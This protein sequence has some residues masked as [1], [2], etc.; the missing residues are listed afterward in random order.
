MTKIT[1][2]N[3]QICLLRKLVTYTKLANYDSIR[4]RLITIL[5]SVDKKRVFEATNG[6]DSVRDI[7]SDT[8]VNKATIS[9]WWNEW[10]KEGI[11]EECKEAKGR[12]SKLLS[13]SDFGIEVPAG[14]K[15]RTI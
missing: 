10:Q 6:R 13:L 7:Q 14:K 12:R 3:E 5:D 8:G 11:V 9:N 1:E 4:N 15:K 2:D